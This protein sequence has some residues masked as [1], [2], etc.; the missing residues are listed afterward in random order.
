ML[1]TAPLMLY[2]GYNFFTN[3]RAHNNLPGKT[4]SLFHPNNILH[5][6][7]AIDSSMWSDDVV[8]LVVTL[9]LLIRSGGYFRIEERNNTQLSLAQIIQFFE[10]KEKIYGIDAKDQKIETKPS[11]MSSRL[12]ISSMLQRASEIRSKREIFLKSNQLYREIHGVL[13][14]KTERLLRSSHDSVFEKKFVNLI[15]ELFP[16]K[17]YTF[18]EIKKNLLHHHE[19]LQ[20]PHREFKT[21]LESLIY[22]S[23]R[24]ISTFINSDFVMSRGMRT[25]KDFVEALKQK[26]FEKVVAWDI[27]HYYCCVIPSASA[28]KYFQKNKDSLADGAWAMA[29]RMQYNSWHMMPGNLPLTP[30]VK[31]RDYFAPPNISDITTFSDFHHRGHVYNHI[32]HTIRSPQPVEI[33]GIKFNGFVDV[34]LLRCDGDKFLE[35]EMLVTQYVANLLAYSTELFASAF[36]VDERSPHSGEISAFDAKW[37]RDWIYERFN[38]LKKEQMC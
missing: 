14:N 28:F 13:I 5:G 17:G 24:L 15:S 36:Q 19:W 2:R 34:R 8:V 35:S 23:L 37:H 32:R 12:S 9:M 10:E 18:A 22:E 33:C 29:A 11:E 31:N 3:F 21:G 4:L 7:H 38:L 16:L 20:T 1:R 26:N 30:E 6:L 25:V 27:P